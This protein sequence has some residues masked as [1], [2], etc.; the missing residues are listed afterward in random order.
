MV[1]SITFIL[2]LAYCLI[3]MGLIG[4]VGNEISTPNEGVFSDY[5]WLFYLFSS[6]PVEIVTA[7]VPAMIIVRLNH[8]NCIALATA[9]AAVVIP[10]TIYYLYVDFAITNQLSGDNL[11]SVI[12]ASAISTLI[13]VGVLPLV[14]ACMKQFSVLTRQGEGQ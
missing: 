5:P 8:K 13:F 9:G 1:A 12:I 2:G 6:I 11:I 4:Y 3:G 14:I 10:L 7:I